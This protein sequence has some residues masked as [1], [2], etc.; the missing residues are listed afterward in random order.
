MTRL[1]VRLIISVIGLCLVT[2]F[3]P[4]ISFDGPW[5]ALVV[6]ALIFGLVN[7]LV[8]PL[9]LGISCL[10]NVLTL[11]LFTFVINALM[12]VLTAYIS[13]LIGAQYGFN[14]TVGF[15]VPAL[16]GAIVI[17]VLSSILSHLIREPK[18]R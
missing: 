14:F 1:L 5:W 4:G 13:Q 18:R 15:P 2:R 12:L 11:G 9:L 17:T 10:L 3:I 6:I 7:A 8:R 16:L